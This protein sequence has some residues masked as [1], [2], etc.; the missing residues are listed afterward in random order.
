MT[1]G[2][3]LATVSGTLA[4]CVSLWAA[5]VLV[6]LLFDRRAHAAAERI[7]RHAMRC[8]GA[9]LLLSGTAGVIALVL[10]KQPNGLFKLIGWVGLALL[11]CLATLGGSGLT[12][13]LAARIRRSAPDLS[14]FGTAGRAAGLLVAAG[15]IPFLGWI[16]AVVSLL[17]NLGAALLSLR[18]PRP[19]ASPAAPVA[20]GVAP[21]RPAPEYVL[22]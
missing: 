14:E 9:G 15:L 11:L 1:I 5:L 6:A 16:I 22:E 10:I 4:A 13:T 21:A 17:A 2:D 19:D 8:I 7:E 12:L 18:R 20:P 3:V